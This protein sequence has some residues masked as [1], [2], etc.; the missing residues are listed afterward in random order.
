MNWL[1]VPRSFWVGG[2]ALRRLFGVEAHLLQLAPDVPS[3]E[4]LGAQR[5]E[6]LLEGVSLREFDR[7]QPI[8]PDAHARVELWRYPLPGTPADEGGGLTGRPCGAGTGWVRLKRFRRAGVRDLWYARFSAPR[9]LSLAEREWNLICYLRAHGVGTPA[10]MAVGRVGGGVFARR[11]FLV[12]REL[13]ATRPLPDA[14]QE[15]RDPAARRALAEA[16][17]SLIARIF[18]SGAVL[19]ELRA[20]DLWVGRARADERAEPAAPSEHLT[21]G[22]LPEVIV[23]AFGRG[24]IQNYVSDPQRITFLRRLASGL[25]DLSR[26]ERMRVAC[27]ADRTLS[28]DKRLWKP[29]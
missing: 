29:L 12:T 8:D 17:G 5:L 6:D 13:D 1:A 26:A 27:H 28:C 3:L 9:S 24:R 14:I 20:R 25:P 19:P 22:A 21:F 4:A 10:P 18:R 15:A 16:T 11:S 7:A 23:T 2:A